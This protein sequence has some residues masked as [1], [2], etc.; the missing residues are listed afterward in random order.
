[1][2]IAHKI[3][4]TVY[5]VLMP[6]IEYRELGDAY[7]DGLDRR[8]VA[9]T[10]VRRLERMGTP[11]TVTNPPLEAFMAAACQV[12]DHRRGSDLLSGHTS[13]ERVQPS[14]PAKGC[15]RERETDSKMPS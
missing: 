12:T 10:L 8:R 1:M 7:L 3:L 6:G 14:Q 15:T 4:L 11:S 5:H 9:R 13:S 2:A